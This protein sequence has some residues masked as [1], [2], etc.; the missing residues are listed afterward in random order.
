MY[1]G[2]TVVQ[3]C[4]SQRMNVSTRAP[5]APLAI[6]DI[7]LASDDLYNS[8]NL[9]VIVFA[10]PDRNVTVPTPH[11]NHD[12]VQSRLRDALFRQMLWLLLNR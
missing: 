3:C 8:T 5:A 9:W 4:V 6:Q 7:H 12:C 1:S 10:H 11:Q 2:E